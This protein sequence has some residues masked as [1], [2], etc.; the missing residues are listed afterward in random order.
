MEKGGNKNC[1]LCR[2]NL[3]KQTA[4]TSK[5][6]QCN[7]FN[8]KFNLNT[9]VK[10]REEKMFCEKCRLSSRING[11]QGDLYSYFSRNVYG[12]WFD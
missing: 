12:L 7:L 1:P 6:K 10:N 3:T 2:S 4:F 5:C 8:V 11:T 9:F